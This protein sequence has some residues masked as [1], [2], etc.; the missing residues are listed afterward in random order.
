[1]LTPHRV[2]LL[3]VSALVFG[4]GWSALGNVPAAEARQICYINEITKT[5]DCRDDGSAGNPGD[6][7]ENGEWVCY[8]DT[9]KDGVPD[10]IECVTEQG[11]WKGTCYEKPV[12]PQPPFEDPLWE[13]RTDGYIA[14]CTPFGPEPDH[15]ECDALGGCDPW[16]SKY[17]VP[18]APGTAPSAEEL[19]RRAV[20][21]MQLQP[22]A[23]GMSPAPTV[24]PPSILINAPTHLYV[25]NPGE[26][27]TGPSTETAS[28]SGLTVTATATLE[29]I[30]WDMGDGTVVTCEGDALL[31]QAWTEDMGWD[32]P[33]CGH[34]YEHTSTDE[35]GG[36]YTVTAV[37]YWGIEWELVGGGEAGSFDY[38]LLASVQVGVRD[39]PAH[40]VP[41][42]TG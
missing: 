34:Y 40:L 27:T 32:E 30:E 7:G 41:D 18:G 2:A 16:I 24:E 33:V 23:I 13:G 20:V 26:A 37:S 9:D 22:I 35:P 3:L 28:D 1:M 12:E 14:Q 36:A 38:D 31:G 17:W 4:I 42:P 21:Q 39:A 19:A 10:E 25:E 5:M 8:W 29:R 11:R 15:M 6:P